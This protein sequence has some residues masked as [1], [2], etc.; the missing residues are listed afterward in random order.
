M[1]LRSRFQSSTI[2]PI[3][4]SRLGPQRLMNA[5]ARYR[6]PLAR[7]CRPRAAD[8]SRDRDLVL[9]ALRVRSNRV[10]Q[11]RSLVLSISNNKTLR[12]VY[13]RY[14]K[15]ATRS[16][17][18]KITPRVGKTVECPGCAKFKDSSLA[19]KRSARA[20]R[21]GPDGEVVIAPLNAS[22]ACA[23]LEEIRGSASRRPA[24]RVGGYFGRCPHSA[25]S[26]RR[27]FRAAAKCVR[28]RQESLPLGVSRRKPSARY[29]RSSLKLF[30]RWRS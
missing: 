28:K 29:H 13:D 19:R 17:S 8:E 11:D 15:G 5:K 3:S 21:L 30:L 26:R 20:F 14:V 25:E 9:S 23:R 2:P 27:R 22:V 6:R 24:R 12:R 4:K 1:G 10:M 7:L 18:R 16:A